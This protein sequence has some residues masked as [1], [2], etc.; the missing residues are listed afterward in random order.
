MGANTRR[1]AQQTWVVILVHTTGCV[2]FGGV[3]SI[4]SSG[5]WV[6]SAHLA[7]GGHLANLIPASR[8]PCHTCTPT[9]GHFQL[10]RLGSLSFQIRITTADGSSA[11][12]AE[13]CSGVRPW[14]TDTALPWCLVGVKR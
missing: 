12:Q 9:P 10:L 11:A 7:L 14:A 3:T 4:S 6:R 13:V 2:L 8:R 5:K 1:R